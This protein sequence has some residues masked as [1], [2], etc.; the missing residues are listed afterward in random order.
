MNTKRKSQL[1]QDKIKTI[2]SD[3]KGFVGVS[4][5]I[6]TDVLSTAIFNAIFKKVKKTNKVVSV[7]KQVSYKANRQ[8]F[9]LMD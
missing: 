7:Q 3:N 5:K 4:G 6:K 8:N 2:T 9:H 1:E